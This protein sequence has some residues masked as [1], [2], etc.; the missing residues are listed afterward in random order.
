MGSSILQVE[1]LRLREV[2]VTHWKQQSWKSNLEL[3]G[4]P[5]LFYHTAFK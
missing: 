1:K 2:T 3:M 4:L 5:W